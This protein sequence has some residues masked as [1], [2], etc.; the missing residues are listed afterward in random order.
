M[1]LALYL[2]V[3]IALIFNRQFDLSAKEGFL[4]AA[5]MSGFVLL[6]RGWSD[7]W[8]LAA[9]WSAAYWLG[10][11]AVWSV[12]GIWQSRRVHHA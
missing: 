5:L 12:R 4:S 7:H 10:V 9:A 3:G 8:P 2:S 1:Y 11:V 6:A